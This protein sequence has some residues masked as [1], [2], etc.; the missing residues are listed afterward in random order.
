M[1]ELTAKMGGMKL[2]ELRGCPIVADRIDCLMITTFAG[3]DPEV[4]RKVYQSGAK[5]ICT[6]IRGKLIGGGKEGSSG[7][8]EGLIWI[9]RERLEDSPCSDSVAERKA[10][11]DKYGTSYWQPSWEAACRSAKIALC[12]VG[13]KALTRSDNVEW[14][15][16]IIDDAFP[17]SHILFIACDQTDSCKAFIEK[18]QAKGRPAFKGTNE[19]DKAAAVGYAAELARRYWK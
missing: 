2:K 8:Y 15:Q 4:K 17:E 9:D 12:F 7:K 11:K 13:D 18:M 10:Y 14:E 5:K 1:D 16:G 6:E 3:N 19:K